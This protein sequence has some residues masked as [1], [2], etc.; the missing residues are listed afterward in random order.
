MPIFVKKLCILQISGWF[1]M[2]VSV[3]LYLTCLIIL[4]FIPLK[5]SIN[6][7]YN[8]FYGI[9]SFG[10]LTDLLQA[11]LFQQSTPESKR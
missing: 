7:F 9:W 2:N 6:T 5:K 1:L 4:C 10:I 8:V 11:V 3:V